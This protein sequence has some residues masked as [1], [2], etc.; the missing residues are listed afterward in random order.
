MSSKRRLT[1]HIKEKI[2]NYFKTL[3]IR[4]MESIEKREYFTYKVLICKVL[5]MRVV[6]GLKYLGDVPIWIPAL[7]PSLSISLVTLLSLSTI[8]SINPNRPLIVFPCIII[9]FILYTKIF[10]GF[11]TSQTYALSKNEYKLFSKINKY[12][13]QEDIHVAKTALTKQLELLNTA[14]NK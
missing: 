10:K 13:S 12:S 5:F 7:L 11:F 4:L 14:M 3:H 1:L 8:F 2:H 9:G 6:F